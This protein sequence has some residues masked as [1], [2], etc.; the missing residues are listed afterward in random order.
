M[1]YL[2]HSLLLLGLLAASMLQAQDERYFRQLLFEYKDKDV[3]QQDKSLYHFVAKSPLYAMDLN[4]DQI[5]E[6]IGF[7]GRDG[8][9]WFF[10]Y[11]NKGKEIFN[12]RLDTMGKDS[13]LYRIRVRKLSSRTK[14]LI[15]YFYQGNY[16]YLSFKGRSRLYFVTIDDKQLD[17]ISA[18]KGPAFWEEAKEVSGHYHQRAYKVYLKDYNRDGIMEVAVSHHLINTIFMY[19]DFGRWREI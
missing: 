1:K 5:N 3:F 19:V 14:L 16:D 11:D 13:S 7:E 9:S 6:Q 2:L 17:K 15:L 8:E 4:G 10:I 18:F 12:Y